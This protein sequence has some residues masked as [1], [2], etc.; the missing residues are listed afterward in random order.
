MTYKPPTPDPETEP[1]IAG[2]LARRGLLI[3]PAVVLV[4]WLAR[5]SDGG[6]SAGFALGLV[7]VNFLL[8][9]HS[10]SWAARISPGA[11]LGTALGGYVVRLA[12]ITA[13]VLSI[14]DLGWVDLPTVG[15]TLVVAHLGLL[16]WELR[17]V[18]LTFAAPGL[19]TDR[20][21]PDG[22]VAR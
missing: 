13:A 6:A 18:S 11:Y 15:F 1:G 17:H 7:M 8:A 9:A 14:R 5:G 19:K 21:A 2:D 16:T 20:R 4:A 12:I 22:G 10:L 3:A